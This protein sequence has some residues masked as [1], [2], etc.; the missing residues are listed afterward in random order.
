MQTRLQALNTEP[1]RYYAPSTCA[2]HE[3][4]HIHVVQ[5]NVQESRKHDV[6]APAPRPDCASGLVNDYADGSYFSPPR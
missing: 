3:S 2:S 6:R 5:T 1:E 4:H